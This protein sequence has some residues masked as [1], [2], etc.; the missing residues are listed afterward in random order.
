MTC[1]AAPPICP[2]QSNLWIEVDTDLAVWHRGG[3]DGSGT[4]YGDCRNFCHVNWQVTCKTGA[5]QHGVS[6]YEFP[7]LLQESFLSDLNAL[8]QFLKK[9]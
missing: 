7:R 6:D 9:V 3:C 4:R 2:G 1:P 5:L 8:T